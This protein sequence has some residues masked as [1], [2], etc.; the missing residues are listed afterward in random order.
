M[1]GVVVLV[2]LGASALMVLLV[3]VF[4]LSATRRTRPDLGP[5]PPVGPGPAPDGSVAPP[6][7]PG[8]VDGTWDAMIPGGGFLG[9]MG[10]SLNATF[11]RIDLVGGRLAF[12]RDGADAPDWQVPCT[13]L[14]IRQ[15]SALAPKGDVE[16][17]GPMGPVRCTV[18]RERVNRFTQNGFKDLREQGYAREFVQ[19]VLTNGA[20][21]G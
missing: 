16:L 5:R 20:V 21:H 3:T 1:T 4:T 10:G 12:T 8:A 15:L 7:R 13:H 9:A 19:A 11:G 2:A 14:R 17:N 6:P 18:S